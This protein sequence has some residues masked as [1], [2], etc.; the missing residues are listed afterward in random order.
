M[1]TLGGQLEVDVGQL[2][3]NAARQRAVRKRRAIR[4]QACPVVEILHLLSAR[5]IQFFLRLENGKIK[6]TKSREHNII[7][8]T[9]RARREDRDRGRPRTRCTS[10]G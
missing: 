10:R 6:R 7:E 9:C 5:C 2:V 4:R 8:I 3:T 1:L